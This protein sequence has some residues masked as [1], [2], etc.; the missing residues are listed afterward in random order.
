METS[1]RKDQANPHLLSLRVSP[2]TSARPRDQGIHPPVAGML[3]VLLE[4]E[5]K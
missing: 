3:C 4:D 5:G 1:L 2:E